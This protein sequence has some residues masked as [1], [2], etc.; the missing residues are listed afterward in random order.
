[1]ILKWQKG[2]GNNI[3][4]CPQRRNKK[5][6]DFNSKI[7]PEMTGNYKRQPSKIS[8][9]STTDH[10]SR[11]LFH[12]QLCLK[13]RNRHICPDSLT[14]NFTIHWSKKTKIFPF[15]GSWLKYNIFKRSKLCSKWKRLSVSIPCSRTQGPRIIITEVWVRF[16]QC[17]VNKM[18]HLSFFGFMRSRKI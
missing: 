3:V 11:A 14:S 7:T 13:L 2:T 8:L 4:I 5:I 18:Q 10:N 6:Q 15:Q 9:P 17:C 16:K 1:M 12:K